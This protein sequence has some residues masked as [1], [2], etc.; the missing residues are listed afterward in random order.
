M[1]LSSLG[2]KKTNILQ[3]VDALGGLLDLTSNNLGDELVGEL[4]ESAGGGLALDDLG[5]LLANGADLRRTSVGGLLDLVGASLGEGNGEQAEE[6]VVSGLH[7]D[8][9]LDQG[10]PLADKGTE[11]VG[12]E[13]ETV[14]VGQAVLALDLVDAELDLAEGVVLIVLE[15][16]EG[17][18]EDTALE[19]VVGVLQTAGAVDQ[20]LADTDNSVSQS[21]SK[22]SPYSIRVV[23]ILAGLEGGRSLS[24]TISICVS[25]RMKGIEH[26]FTEYSSLRVKGS[27]VRF[28]IPFLPLDRRLFLNEED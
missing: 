11:L 12:G 6:V 3:G 22:I 25:G 2:G 4:G 9:G 13:V 21:I 20:S 14:E 10:L 23:C 17:D 19:G 16:G 24:R 26:T 27:T 28:L 15:V 5:H 18:L 7:G 1:R 8:V